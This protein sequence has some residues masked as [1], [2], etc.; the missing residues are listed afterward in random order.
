M[1]A[2]VEIGVDPI[3][4]YA[5]SSFAWTFTATEE[6]LTLDWGDPDIRLFWTWDSFELEAPEPAPRTAL[7]F[8]AQIQRKKDIPNREWIE[9][10][11]RDSLRRAQEEDDDQ[12]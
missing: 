6:G 2:V 7:E 5:S 3:A 9:G 10:A 1:K 4:K 8:K 11:M 12:T